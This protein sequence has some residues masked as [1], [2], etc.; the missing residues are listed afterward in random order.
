MYRRI[1]KTCNIRIYVQEDSLN[2]QYM[3]LCTA[4]FIKHAIYVFMYRKVHKTCNVFI[5]RK[6]K[7]ACN[8]FIY[9]KDD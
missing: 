7:K 2:M 6:I 9:V 8:K 5:Y 1:H 3:H 4:G